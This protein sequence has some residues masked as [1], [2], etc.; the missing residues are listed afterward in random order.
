[1]VLLVLKYLGIPSLFRDFTSKR[2][3]YHG[4]LNSTTEKY[5]VVSYIAFIY[6][7]ASHILLETAKMSVEENA[8]ISSLCSQHRKREQSKWRVNMKSCDSGNWLH[9]LGR[10]AS[11]PYN[12]HKLYLKTW[13]RIPEHCMLLDTGLY[14]LCAIPCSYKSTTVSLQKRKVLNIFPV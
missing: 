13:A 11:T 12:A 10:S 7:G 5:K 4:P 3:K 8:K 1:M 6:I 14:G 9:F 2:K